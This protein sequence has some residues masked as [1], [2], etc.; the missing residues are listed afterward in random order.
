MKKTIKIKTMVELA[1]S[2]LAQ[3]LSSPEF[4]RGVQSLIESALF[5]T[6]TYG[7]FRYLEEKEVPPGRMP[8]IRMSPDGAM[9]PYEQRFLNT[10]STR[11]AYFAR[12]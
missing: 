6:D 2:C 4:R 11:V 8:G 1:N 7:G 12:G 10:D 3:S 5:Q 9:L